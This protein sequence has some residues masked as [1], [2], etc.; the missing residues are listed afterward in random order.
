[1]KVIPTFEFG[2]IFTKNYLNEVRRHVHFDLITYSHLHE[3]PVTRRPALRLTP[4]LIF[5]YNQPNLFLFSVD[6]L[7]RDYYFNSSFKTLVKKK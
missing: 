2:R 1:M 5:L 6:L 7:N 4:L 3:D